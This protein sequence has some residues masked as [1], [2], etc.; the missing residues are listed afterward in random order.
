MRSRSRRGGLRMRHR[1]LLLDEESSNQQR[2]R[3]RRDRDR[4]SAPMSVRWPQSQA[5]RT[6]ATPP[7]VYRATVIPAAA[8]GAVVHALAMPHGA[9]A[10]M[11]DDPPYR[12]ELAQ[13]NSELEAPQRPRRKSRR[14]ATPEATLSSAASRAA[15][16]SAASSAPAACE[17]FSMRNSIARIAARRRVTEAASS[18]ASGSD[19]AS[20]TCVAAISFGK[21]SAPTI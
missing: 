17:I 11:Q 3:G 13:S 2:L 20:A 18:P 4:A 19:G 21:R 7:A 1:L 5:S 15:A 6:A 10:G 9:D 8:S 14:R 12:A 16:G